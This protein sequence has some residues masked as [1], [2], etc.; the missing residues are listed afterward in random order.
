MSRGELLNGCLFVSQAIVAK[1]EVAIAGVR[2]AARRSSAAM[3]DLNDH[4]AKLSKLLIA[5]R[6]RKSMVGSFLLGAWIDMGD[7]R[8]SLLGVEVKRLPQIAVQISH[9]IGRLDDECFG[10]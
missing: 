2:L 5:G 7:D 1:I 4:K 9:A 10:Q 8:I 3:A 6:H